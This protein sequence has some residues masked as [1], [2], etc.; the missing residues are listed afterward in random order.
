MEKRKRG[1]PRKNVKPLISEEKGKV[2]VAGTSSPVSRRRP[3]FFKLFL[4]DRS[5]QQLI[6]ITGCEYG[7]IGSGGGGGDEAG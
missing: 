3:E 5:S 2:T 4:S 7:A 6:N 1:R